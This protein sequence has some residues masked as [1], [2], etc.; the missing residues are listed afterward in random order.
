M[1]VFNDN[2]TQLNDTQEKIYTY[3]IK[4]AQEKE[5]EKEKAA[6]FKNSRVNIE[7]LLLNYFKNIESE[8]IKKSDFTNLLNDIKNNYINNNNFSEY[9]KDELTLFTTKK[10]D[11]LKRQKIN[12]LRQIKKQEEQLQKKQQKEQ[13]KKQDRGGFSLG[14]SVF[15]W[16]FLGLS[17]FIIFYILFVVM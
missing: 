3:N 10:L 14:D 11:Q 8:T 12:Q 17:G 6:R 13:E 4:Q 5:A 7:I 2:L 1:G 16:S 9:Q 15:F